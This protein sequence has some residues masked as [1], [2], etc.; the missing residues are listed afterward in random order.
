MKKL[1]KHIKEID[2]KVGNRI[3]QTRIAL[4][5]SRNNLA[6]AICVSQQQLA[7]YEIGKNRISIGRL[8]LLAESLGKSISYFCLEK[9]E[10]AD[11]L[12]LIDNIG[13]SKTYLRLIKLISKLNDKKQKKALNI[14]IDRFFNNS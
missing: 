11:V 8:S 1:E 13:D 9:T 5:I 7:K 10:T 3:Y 12:S 6:K 4:G 14:L 2:I